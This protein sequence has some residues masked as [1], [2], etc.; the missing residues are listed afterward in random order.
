MT[1]DDVLAQLQALGLQVDTL[2]TSG[3]L[4][5][6]PVDDDKGSK[7]SGWYVLHE[8]RLDSGDVAYAGRYGN[9]K[10]GDEAHRI[11]VSTQL[12]DADRAAYAEKR[13][14]AQRAQAEERRTR[15][16]DAAKRAAQIWSQL[17]EGGRSRYLDRKKIRAH[18]ARFARGGALAIPVSGPAGDLV[19]L[20]FIQPTGAKKFLTGTPKRG[21]S[22]TIGELAGAERIVVVEGYATGATVHQATGLP[23]VV[24]FDAGNLLP[25]T[26][27][28]RAQH[29]DAVLLI[30][31]DDDHA[32]EGN[33]GRS[34]ALAVARRTGGRALFPRFIDPAGKTDWNDL[35]VAEGLDEVRAQWEQALAL[36]DDEAEGLERE[37]VY[38]ALAK[39]RS[40][41]PQ[42]NIS[43]VCRVLR[44]DARW[45]GTLAY[46][47][48][49]HRHMKT[50]PTPVSGEAGEWT[51]G[52]TARLRVWLAEQ[53]GFCPGAP[54]TDD[55]M[56]VVS[57]EHP[58]HP[59][60]DY[61][62]ALVWDG[63]ER[64]R[65][66][67]ADYLGTP[68]RDYEAAV[69]T[70]WLI[71]AVARVMQPPCKAD[72]VL[73]L[74]GAQGLGKS[75]ALK[76]LG[77]EWF[78]DVHFQLGDKDGYQA[79]QGCWIV[80]LSE[81]DAF[82]KAE[83]T[84]AKQF[85]ATDV[86]RYRPSYGRRAQDFP[87]MCVFA[88][89]TNQDSYLRDATG[90][91]RYWP[92]RCEDINVEALTEARDQ[93]W[94][95]AM[96]RWREGVPWWPTPDE[97]HLFAEEQ[98]HRFASDSWE[99][100][101]DTWLNAFE[102]RGT[103]QFTS[104]Q[105]LAGALKLE[106]HQMKPPEQTRLGLVMTRLGW[107]KRKVTMKDAEGRSRRQHVYCR[108]CAAPERG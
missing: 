79:L 32:T 43:N 36:L 76:V 16:A 25:V 89:S 97:A 90:N 3:R 35:H 33:P 91:R 44:D 40:G 75:T 104:G 85:F 7:R 1:L 54:D 26:D 68:Q 23:V 108:P 81:L 20:Q 94:A 66:W 18:G 80:E 98:E 69:G 65:Y 57:E 24:A 107:P 106:P 101:V 37:H 82:N 64:L 78:S 72:C 31:G 8:F 2:D 52:D 84:R 73:I 102:Q 61:L 62:S 9:W 38:Q 95:E 49:S 87:R 45:R 51:T 14:A 34:K 50:G 29:R 92:V 88:G 93:L 11:D 39:T 21:A 67:L 17:P 53:Y 47:Q 83:S 59:V 58:M 105:I 63:T 70:K 5:R 56:L 22:F 27:A 74:E 60:R 55:A 30:A 103:E 12:S 4:V 77:G 99:E 86:D 48:H 41:N 96:V 71:A 13:R 42:A 100:L 19:G 28:L 10:A 15:V 46:C 6:V